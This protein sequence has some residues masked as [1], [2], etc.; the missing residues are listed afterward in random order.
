MGWELL[1]ALQQEVGG[2]GVLHQEV[3]RSPGRI[4]DQVSEDSIPLEL[5]VRVASEVWGLPG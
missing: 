2:D 5:G 3:A 1:K 4:A